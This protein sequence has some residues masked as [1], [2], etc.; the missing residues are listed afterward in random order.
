MT[1][2]MYQFMGLHDTRGSYSNSMLELTS[3]WSALRTNL[4]LF[5][6]KTSLRL[7]FEQ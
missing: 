5:A 2:N 6:A 4:E 1:S 7:D 3:D